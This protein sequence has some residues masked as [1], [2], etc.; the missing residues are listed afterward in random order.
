MELLTLQAILSDE[1]KRRDLVRRELNAI[2]ERYSDARRTEILSD[3]G[4]FPLPSGDAAQEMHVFLTHQG[5]LKTL[6]ARSAN[7]DGGL[8]AAE[9]LESGGGDFVQRLWLCKSDEQLLAFTRDGQVHAARIADLPQGTRSSRGKRVGDLLE[10]DSEVA[11][12]HTVRDFS[13]DRFV[14][15]ATRKGRVKRTPLSEYGN[16]RS[17]GI[18][19][20]G[21]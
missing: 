15:M 16:I 7:N 9:S 12:V 18:I 13:D 20:A 1:K 14:V 8:A 11:A 17:G 10:L 19:A 5:H 21:V 2:A 4:R 6:P 3:E